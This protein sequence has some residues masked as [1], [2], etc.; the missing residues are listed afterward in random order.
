MDGW[1]WGANQ[2]RRKQILRD[3]SIDGIS[4]Y[5]KILLILLFGD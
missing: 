5:F 2:T 1:M 4:R 3:A